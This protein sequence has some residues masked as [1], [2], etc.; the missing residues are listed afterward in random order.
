MALKLSADLKD[1]IITQGIITKLAGTAGTAGTCT[2]KIY[3]GSQPTN[4]D[5]APSGTNSTMLCEIINVGWGGTIGST[6]GT[7]QLGSNGG[8]AGTAAATGTAGWARL[9]TIGTGYTGSAATFV[10]DGDV[11]TASTSTFVINAVAI[12][13]GGTVTLL[14][15]P[16]KIS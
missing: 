9:Q 4:A 8:M 3:T 15:A 1:Y 13:G 11:G 10:I 6:S 7:A 2:L 16:I 12:T 14:T 5:T